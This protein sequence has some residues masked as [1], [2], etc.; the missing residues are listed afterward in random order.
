M[1]GLMARWSRAFLKSAKTGSIGGKR[2]PLG[3]YRVC[4]TAVETRILQPR[5]QECSPRITYR[6]GYAIFARK[7]LSPDMARTSDWRWIC[8]SRTKLRNLRRQQP[9]AAQTIAGFRP[10]CGISRGIE[11]SEPCQTC[12]GLMLI[13]IPLQY[14]PRMF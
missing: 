5:F 3:M 10:V 9:G 13:K 12:N 6:I 8:R 1:E 11:L 14:L 4:A 2:M 7:S